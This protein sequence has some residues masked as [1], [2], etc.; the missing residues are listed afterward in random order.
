MLITYIGTPLYASLCT[1]TSLDLL[2]YLEIYFLTLTLISIGEGQ[3]VDT[4]LTLERHDMSRP[5]E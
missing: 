2:G 4:I 5:K 3:T 1:I